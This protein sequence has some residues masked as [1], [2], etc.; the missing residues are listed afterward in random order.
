MSSAVV[1]KPV[2]VMN[3]IALDHDVEAGEMWERKLMGTWAAGHL[4]KGNEE[5]Q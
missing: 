2:V 3:S 5:L 4:P 1:V